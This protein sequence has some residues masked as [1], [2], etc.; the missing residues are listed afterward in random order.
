MKADKEQTS[1]LTSGV[2]LMKVEGPISVSSSS[3][4][5]SNALGVSGWFSLSTVCTDIS[6]FPPPVP[7]AAS[8]P[9]SLP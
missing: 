2:F 1:V 7:P 5:M 3:V 9:I 6:V 4:T 8:T